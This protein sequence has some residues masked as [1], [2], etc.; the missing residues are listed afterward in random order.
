L[1]VVVVSVLVVSVLVA[2][3]VDGVAGAAAE[4]VD[5]VVVP[6]PEPVE[7]VAGAAGVAGTAGVAGVVVDVD[8]EVDVSVTV[9]DVFSG[10]FAGGS[11]PQAVAAAARA[12]AVKRTR[13][14]M[15]GLLI[16]CGTALGASTVVAGVS[17]LGQLR[18]A[19]PG[20][21]THAYRSLAGP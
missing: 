15:V 21:S 5:G 2:V 4:S 6:R 7:G 17:G 3:S 11:P 18:V 20:C 19:R 14:F 12:M 10:D 13:D 16:S 9:P 1:V 8:V